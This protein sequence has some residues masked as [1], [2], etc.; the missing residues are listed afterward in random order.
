MYIFV[1]YIR[2]LMVRSE[3]SGKVGHDFIRS[4]NRASVSTL[5]SLARPLAC[6][7]E[8]LME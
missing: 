3:R 8:D 2:I 5:A 4:H 6:T 7:I 1:C